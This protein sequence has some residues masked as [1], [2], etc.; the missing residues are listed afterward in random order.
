MSFDKEEIRGLSSEQ[1]RRSAETLLDEAD[2]DLIGDQ[3]EEFSA[4]V[5]YARERQAAEQLA[6]HD[7]ITK[8]R[9]GARV[10]RGDRSDALAAGYVES[11]VP[12]GTQ[13]RDSAM[14]HPRPVRKGRHAGSWRRGNHRAAPP[15]RGPWR[16]V[17]DRSLGDQ[18]GDPAYL[19]AF[20]KLLGN[21]ERGHLEWTAEECEA[22]RAVKAVQAERAMSTTDSAGGFLIPFQLDPSIILSGDGSTNPLRQ[23]ARVVQIAGDSWN[24]VTSEGVDAHWYAEAAEVSDD[25]PTLGSSAPHR[26][27]LPRL[28]LCAV[29]HRD[30]RRRRG[31]HVGDHPAAGRRCR[32]AHRCRLHDRQRHRGPRRVS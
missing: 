13:E 28:G 4:L 23:M 12:S 16:K 15:D 27:G 9:A 10:E 6:Q 3:A 30:S 20:A 26:A 18:R 22:F 7:L 5:E 1:A 32:A 21:P 19:R 29:Q 17:L 2:G 11:P 25:T 14:P 8:Y 31:V 24:G